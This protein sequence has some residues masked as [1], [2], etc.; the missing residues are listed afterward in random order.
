MNKPT[1]SNESEIQSFLQ[2]HSEWNFEENNLVATFMFENFKLVT[3][4]VKKVMSAMIEL[5]HH[6]DLMVT[7]SAVTI[8][9][10]THDA[11]NK[12][13]NKDTEIAKRIS[14]IAQSTDT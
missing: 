10:T 11:G 8:K 1:T 7:Y 14:K 4:F 12:V 3:A 9:T 13:S 5:N 6:P 2:S